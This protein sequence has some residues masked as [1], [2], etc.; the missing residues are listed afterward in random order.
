MSA[1]ALDIILLESHEA[2]LRALLHR[3]DGS[4]AAAYVLF[5]KAAFQSGVIE[6]ADLAGHDGFRIV[7]NHHSGGNFNIRNDNIKLH[8]F[9]SSNF[10]FLLPKIHSNMIHL[11]QP[12]I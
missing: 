9:I 1:A 7:D 4:E 11:K 8:F 5:G 12:T 2:A 10:L 6:A 3:E